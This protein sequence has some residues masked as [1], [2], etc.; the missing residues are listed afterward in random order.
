MILMEKNTDVTMRICNL[1]EYRDN[2]S[3]TS[4]NLWQFKRNKLPVTNA[5]NSDNVKHFRKTR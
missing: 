1:I 5:N 2:Y 3:S 4:G